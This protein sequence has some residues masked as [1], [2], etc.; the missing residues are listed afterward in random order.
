MVGWLEEGD[1]DDD[2]GVAS[3]GSVGDAACEEERCPRHKLTR[4]VTLPDANACVFTVV[5]K[6]NLLD[7][8][9]MESIEAKAEEERKCRE[10]SELLNAVR[11][12]QKLRRAVQS[13]KRRE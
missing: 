12:R 5:E 13:T 1:G 9:A 10:K 3:V 6:V 2:D 4:H 7:I 11:H 8:A